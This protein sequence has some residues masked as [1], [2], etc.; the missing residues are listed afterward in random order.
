MYGEA[1]FTQKDVY[2]WAKLFKE[3][4]NSIKDEDRLAR[5][6]MASTP[7]MVDSVNA[8]ILTNR[9]VTIEDIS[10]QLGISLLSTQNCAR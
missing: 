1:W 7:E 10:E 2:K 9:K 8:L 5:N 6:T 3:S 4:R